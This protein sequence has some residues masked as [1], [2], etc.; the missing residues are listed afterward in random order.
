MIKGKLRSGSI[1][2]PPLNIVN[3]RLFPV[4]TIYSNNTISIWVDYS[5]G[6]REIYTFGNGKCLQKFLQKPIRGRLGIEH[7]SLETMSDD[8]AKLVVESLEKHELID[9]FCNDVG[10]PLRFFESLRDSLKGDLK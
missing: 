4:D 10:F 3:I 9:D 2:S 5:S 1:Y 8:L 6:E 7:S